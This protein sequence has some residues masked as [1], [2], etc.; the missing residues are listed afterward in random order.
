M[1][2]T[3]DEQSSMDNKTHKRGVT[4]ARESTMIEDENEHIGALQAGEMV[5]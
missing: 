3:Y 5:Q 4:R 1:R 2:S